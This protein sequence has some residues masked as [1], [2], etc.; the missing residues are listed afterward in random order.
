M[1]T[2]ESFLGTTGVLN[3][4]MSIVVILYTI[5]GFFGYLKFGDAIEASIT[6]NLPKKDM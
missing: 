2:P 3:V 5:F 6:L 1:K 4:G